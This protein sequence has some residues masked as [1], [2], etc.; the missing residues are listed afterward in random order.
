MRKDGEWYGTYITPLV[1][2]IYICMKFANIGIN[3]F[4][5]YTILEFWASL[6]LE[7]LYIAAG[8]DLNSEKAHFKTM[9]NYGSKGALFFCHQK[10][11]HYKIVHYVSY[12]NV[13]DKY[14][15]YSSCGDFMS[16]SQL[17]EVLNVF[18]T[19]I[20]QASNK[21]FSNVY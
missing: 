8:F 20:V 14:A 2:V 17:G 15:A 1:L 4:V 5:W 18:V 11:I 10:H 19:S 21:L 7:N 3:K 13:L 16:Y 12:R 9:I 6:H